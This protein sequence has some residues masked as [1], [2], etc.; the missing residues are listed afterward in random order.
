M[1]PCLLS[2]S[3]VYKRIGIVGGLAMLRREAAA[4][5]A[6]VEGCGPGEPGEGAVPVAGCQANSPWGHMRPW[7]LVACAAARRG[8]PSAGLLADPTL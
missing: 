3:P 4:Y 5:A 7:A 1:A 8:V 6:A 2:R